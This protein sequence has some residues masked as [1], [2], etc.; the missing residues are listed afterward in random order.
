MRA[1]LLAPLLASLALWVQPSFSQTVTNLQAVLDAISEV[2]QENADFYKDLMYFITADDLYQY[3]DEFAMDLAS[4]T[5]SQFSDMFRQKNFW[6]LV[7]LLNTLDVDEI[8]RLTSHFDNQKLASLNDLFSEIGLDVDTTLSTVQTIDG[9]T[10]NFYWDGEDLKVHDD[11]LLTAVGDIL[12]NFPTV[13]DYS[14]VL[15]ALLSASSGIE[16]LSDDALHAD[17]EFG[18]YTASVVDSSF[19]RDADD[20]ESTT[21]SIANQHYPD[22]KGELPALDIND[23]NP[24][25][26]F[27]ISTVNVAGIPVLASSDWVPTPGGTV[28]TIL[29]SSEASAIMREGG[30]N[31]SMPRLEISSSSMP[32]S[33]SNW[34]NEVRD[35]MLLVYTWTF[36]IL[37]VAIILTL[38]I[39]LLRDCIVNARRLSA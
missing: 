27:S 13:P 26:H 18:G 30:V 17:V 11:E 38:W 37:R 14:D 32:I 8:N 2:R 25:S 28:A 1:S 9:W 3:S 20:I 5:E 35:L 33:V 22:N 23:P 16:Q 19:T 24:E 34:V 7:D 12:N 31:V 39:P 29:S 4:Y 15:Q 10:S 21:Y 36:Q 6:V